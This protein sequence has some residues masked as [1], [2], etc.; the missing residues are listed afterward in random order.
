MADPAEKA[1]PVDEP[2]IQPTNI[3]P[4]DE[5]TKLEIVKL[6]DLDPMKEVL[7]ED[8][9]PNEEFLKEFLKEGV[10]IGTGSE[11]DVY[12]ADDQK[13][14][15]LCVKKVARTSERTPY[16][17]GIVE[18]M[19]RQREA[20]NILDQLKEDEEGKPVAK[21]PAPFIYFTAPGKER[22]QEY[23]L[24]E[25]APGK[26]LYRMILELFIE[27]F[28]EEI[29][30]ETLDKMDDENF[31][32]MVA[33]KA[34]LLEMFEIK[35]ELKKMALLLERLSRKGKKFL[36]KEFFDVLQRAVITLNSSGFYHRDLHPRNIMVS[37][38]AVSLIDFG[39]SVFDPG[40]Q[41]SNPYETTELG[42]TTSFSSDKGTLSMLEE[43]VIEEGDNKFIEAEYKIAER[44][45]DQ[46][47]KRRSTIKDVLKAAESQEID[48]EQFI[49][50]ITKD[51]VFSKA[52]RSAILSSSVDNII[53]YAKILA[54]FEYKRFQSIKATTHYLEKTIES[55]R[56]KDS[57]SLLTRVQAALKPF[58]P[59][60]N[61]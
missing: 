5:P 52:M 43:F 18:E 32:S 50:A 35:S 2:P 41:L 22:D 1:Q 42:E 12:Q 17:P 54:S 7:G 56:P 3:Q 59:P 33:T 37:E 34:N 31:A 13:W 28:D 9:E 20:R 11:A 14:R 26:T 30:R 19:N 45:T 25:F 36:K 53:K 27:E 21:V 44:F 10:V 38:D 4:A 60:V 8:T 24:M 16:N 46:L 51:P 40:K 49:E 61:E 55:Y 48:N 29:N 15:H 6:W 39:Y 47:A 23:I 57:K 58:N